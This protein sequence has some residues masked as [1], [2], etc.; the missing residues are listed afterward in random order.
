MVRKEEIIKSL[1]DVRRR[2]TDLE[3]EKSRLLISRDSLERELQDIDRKLEFSESSKSSIIQNSSAD[4]KI[5]LFCKLFRGRRDVFPTRWE[6][7]KSGR[8][9]YSPAC[10]NEWQYG[11]CAKPKVK[12]G[13]CPNQ[14]F[15]PLTETIIAKH[16]RGRDESGREFIA[17]IYPL[18]SDETCWFIAADFD[19][20]T[21]I[22][23]TRAFMETCRIKGVDAALERSRSG[24][25]G[26]IWIFFEEPIPARIARQMGASLL[27]E[28]M[29]RRPEIG[30]S[31]YDRFFPNQDTM[32]LG[33]FGNLIA[34][35]LQKSARELGNSVFVD[36]NLTPFDD[37]WA[38]LSSIKRNPSDVVFMIA[39]AAE[40][41][42]AIL[43]VRMPVDDEF[44]HEPWKISPSRRS[45]Q[46][47]APKDLPEKISIVVAD[48]IYVDKTQLP[49]LLVTQLIR[50]AAFQNPE[51][52]RAQAMR[53]PIY[54]KPRIIS[55]AELHPLHISLPRGCYDEVISLIRGHGVDVVV[56]DQQQIGE[57]SREFY[58]NHKAK[59]LM[60]LYPTTVA[61]LLQPQ[62][63][64]KPSS[65][66][67]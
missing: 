51:F 28:T 33:G 29:E 61:Y 46:L 66:R 15:I 36:D 22:D 62:P 2:L 47:P 3:N 6:N 19:K 45:R 67:R 17:G 32:P 44:A 25:G 40:S 10:S 54:D 49:P 7:R 24:K 23:D 14:S 13:E 20:E 59:H 4:E 64:A 12:C 48:Q 21:W 57:P 5:S 41:S 60:I 53:L 18:Q 27:T 58:G 39:E 26:H 31:S 11:I 42:G 63:L 50:L 30:F 37:Q 16:L 35:P 65:Q 52:Y 55:C 34:L 9:G 56:D 43:G 1:D 38:F 8:T